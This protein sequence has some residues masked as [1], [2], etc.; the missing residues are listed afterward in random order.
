MS[1]DATNRTDVDEPL[2]GYG[3]TCR[4]GNGC[5]LHASTAYDLRPEP[6]LLIKTHRKI[7]IYNPD[8]AIRLVKE[9]LFWGRPM[10]VFRNH[11]LPHNGDL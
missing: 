10:W 8:M 4:Q 2:V 9:D 3:C 6:N 11:L 1:A 7:V 5:A